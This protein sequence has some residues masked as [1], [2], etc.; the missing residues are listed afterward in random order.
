MLE[1]AAFRSGIALLVTL[2]VLTSY[3]VSFERTHRSSP[4]LWIGFTLLLVIIVFRVSAVIL[5]ASACLLALSLFGYPFVWANEYLIRSIIVVFAGFFG[6]LLAGLLLQILC[7][8][9]RRFFGMPT[10]RIAIWRSSLFRRRTGKK[11]A[12]HRS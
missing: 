5:A 9:L 8:T 2:I 12:S 11:R 3:N 1:V 7:N 10:K 4:P 6:L